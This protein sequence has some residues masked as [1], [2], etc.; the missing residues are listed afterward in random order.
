MLDI[1]SSDESAIELV[2]NG[3]TIALE[4]SVALVN[5]NSR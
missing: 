5:N 1:R 3:A 2:M 4:E